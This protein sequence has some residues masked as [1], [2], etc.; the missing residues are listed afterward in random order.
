M[1]FYLQV[2]SHVSSFNGFRENAESFILKN[3]TLICYSVR[4]N[5]FTL[6]IFMNW[7][8]IAWPVFDQ[9]STSLI[10]NAMTLNADSLFIRTD[11][12]AR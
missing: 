5:V 4:S 3:T 11:R 9:S 12:D 10:T 6:F 2:K 8:S 1:L 7:V